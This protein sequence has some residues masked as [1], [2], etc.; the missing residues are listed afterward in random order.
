MNKTSIGLIAL[1]AALLLTGC[2]SASN[3]T[4]LNK[5]LN[6]AAQAGDTARVQQML[7]QGADVNKEVPPYSFT[8][9]MC[10]AWYGNANVVE[11]LLGKGVN[12]NAQ[13]QMGWTALMQAAFAGRTECVKVLL[14]H[15]A[16]LEVKNDHGQTASDLA[17]AGGQPKTAALIEAA[18]RMGITTVEAA[19]PPLM[20]KNNTG[21]EPF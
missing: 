14:A 15:N 19:V 8:P 21:T 12:I 20:P 16:S 3:K 18:S 9:L 10:A 6:Q 2:A 11:L 17:R 7:D 5:M 1:A 13:N 4:T